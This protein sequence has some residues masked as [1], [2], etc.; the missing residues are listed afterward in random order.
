MGFWHT[1]AGWLKVIFA[2]SGRTML[3]GALRSVVTLTETCA[4]YPQVDRRA[5]SEDTPMRMTVRLLASCGTM[6]VVLY[7]EYRWSWAPLQGLHSLVNG[8]GRRQ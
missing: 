5:V 8:R 2:S 4:G 6:P 1:C 7:L 3:A